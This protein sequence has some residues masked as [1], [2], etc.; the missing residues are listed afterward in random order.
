MLTD[1]YGSYP[2]RAL[3]Q[4]CQSARHHCG[5]KPIR[6]HTVQFPSNGSRGQV[7]EQI[8]ESV[9]QQAA[10]EVYIDPELR[11]KDWARTTLTT[12]SSPMPP[13]F[14]GRR[15]WSMPLTGMPTSLHPA[16]TRRTKNRWGQ[17]GL[18]GPVVHGGAPF[19]GPMGPRD[20]RPLGRQGRDLGVPRGAPGSGSP[21]V[22]PGRASIFVA[23]IASRE[24][25]PAAKAC[26]GSE[27]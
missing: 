21:A 5:G 27:E 7:M 9:R 14:P 4:V 12:H 23:G 24:E 2:G 13:F 15:S 22:R 10:G 16:G 17:V 26:G 8:A 6:F 1:G 18:A 20:R 25:E 11:E 19:H 3:A